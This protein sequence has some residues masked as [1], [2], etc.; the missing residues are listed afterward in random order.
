MTVKTA[1]SLDKELLDKVESLASEM[2][3]SRGTVFILAI[4]EFLERHD[5]AGVVA[6]LNA[7]YGGTPDAQ[8]AELLDLHRRR[9]ATLQAIRKHSEGRFSSDA[10]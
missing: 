6:S 9:H 3:V 4:K 1:I 8:D 2:Q 5:D 7:V 10:V